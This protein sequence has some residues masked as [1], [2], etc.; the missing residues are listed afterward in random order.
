MADATQQNDS[1]I[2]NMQES[3]EELILTDSSKTYLRLLEAEQ[4]LLEDSQPRRGKGVQTDTD[5]ARAEN[6]RVRIATINSCLQVVGQ[7]SE[8]VP[9]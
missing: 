1:R 8:N 2:N 6:F 3:I 7:N 9:K 4:E 5:V